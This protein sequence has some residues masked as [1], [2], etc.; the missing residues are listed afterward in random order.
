MKRKKKCV[1]NMGKFVFIV[2][3]CCM[4]NAGHAKL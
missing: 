2:D 4:N 3:I 1:R